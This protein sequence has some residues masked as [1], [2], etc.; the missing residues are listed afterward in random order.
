MGFAILNK[1]KNTDSVIIFIHIPK[2]AGSTLYSIIYKQYENM[3]TKDNILQI[4]WSLDT[5]ME[6]NEKIEVLS[7]HIQFGV[8]KYLP[9]KK[10]IYLTMIR[11][12]IELV[13]SYYYY[14][15]RTKTHQFYN[16]FNEITLEEFVTKEEF[17]HVTTN[18]QT[19]YLSEEYKDDL[20][21]A[22]N[23]LKKHFKIVGVTER[24]EDTLNVV[25]KELGWKIEDYKSINKAKDRPSVKEIPNK[26][27]EIIQRKN[28]NDTKIYLFANK[29]LDEKLEQLKS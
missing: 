27:I 18:L 13:L 25:K 2:T 23:N 9:Q 8:H 21:I 10:Y 15:Q 6:Q 1:K 11:N 28:E 29:L 14:V 3:F 5:P 12:P 20:E 4:P 16:L 24:F 22:R 17:N 19:R 7:G 26:V